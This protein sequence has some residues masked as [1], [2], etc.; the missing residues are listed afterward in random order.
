MQIS[1]LLKIFYLLQGEYLQ[2]GYKGGAEQLE[3]FNN[4]GAHSVH[5]HQEASGG[6]QQNKGILPIHR[7]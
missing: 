2:K 4:L 7:R 5:G 1:F 3:K 6:Y